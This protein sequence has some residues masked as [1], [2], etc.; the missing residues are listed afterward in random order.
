VRRQHVLDQLADRIRRLPDTHPVRVAVDGIDAAG[1]TTLADELVPLLETRG[2][3]VIRASLDGFHR[4]RSERYQRGAD[5]AEGYYL[6]AFDYPAHCNALLLPL[7]PLGSR[8]YRQAVFDFR[9]DR[10]LRQPEEEAPV[11]AMLVLD[12]VFL[13][14]PELT[15]FWDYRIWVEV[16]LDVALNRAR[17]RDVALFGSAEAVEAR[18]RTRYIPGQQLYLEAAGPRKQAEAIVEN[19]DP[20]NP[21]LHF[22]EGR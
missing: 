10:P 8:R 15:T 17:Q 19:A 20:A 14:R 16:P 2:R 3:P 12:G 1:K 9:A 7:C 21:V 4:P 5:S 6:D 18:Y 22:R 13:L 11:D